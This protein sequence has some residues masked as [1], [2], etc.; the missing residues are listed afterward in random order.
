MLMIHIRETLIGPIRSQIFEIFHDFQNF[1]NHQEY[2]RSLDLARMDISPIQVCSWVSSRH[3]SL[4]LST[5]HRY[6]ISFGSVTYA[7]VSR[8]AD[9]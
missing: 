1:E 3:K 8:F 9:C 4:C 7:A 6:F 2:S 5:I